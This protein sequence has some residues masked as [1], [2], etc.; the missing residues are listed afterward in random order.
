[1]RNRIVFFAVMFALFIFMPRTAAAWNCT[2]PGQI[3]IQV[4]AG[5]LGNGPGDGNG[6]VDTV[7]GI[8]FECEAL[9]TAGS[10]SSSSSS[11]S[12]NATGGQ[13]GQGGSASS[14][15]TGGTQ[16]STTSANGSNSLNIAASS[17]SAYAPTSLPSAPCV[18]SFGVGV[19]SQ[20]AGISFGGNKID[21]GCDERELARSYALLGAKTA[22]CKILVSNEKSQKAG[23]TMT[24]CMGPVAP[25]VASIQGA[26]VAQADTVVT[27]PEESLGAYARRVVKVQ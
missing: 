3:R 24:D 10:P 13:G 5:T 6:Q 27:A 19:Q 17:A 12:A 18:K 2:V 22:A 23:V 1:M 16:S 11:S 15:A 26:I 21:T 25:A 14:S 9:P 4:P 7:E 20:A 8:T